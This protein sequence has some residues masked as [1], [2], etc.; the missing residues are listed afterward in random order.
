MNI[1][2]VMDADTKDKLKLLALMNRVSVSKMV[3][4]L[5][6]W[7]D[8]EAHVSLSDKDRRRVIKK[9]KKYKEGL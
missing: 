1:T 7:A 8:K 4:M 5:V 2:L 9:F 3:R 6:E